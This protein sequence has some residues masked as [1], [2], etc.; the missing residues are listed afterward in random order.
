MTRFT[1]FSNIQNNMQYNGALTKKFD[2]IKLKSTTG[3]E[4]LKIFC[5]LAEAI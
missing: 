1:R 3:I 5:L 2:T 4:Y